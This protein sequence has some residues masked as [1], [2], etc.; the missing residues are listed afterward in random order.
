MPDPL[1]IV[2]IGNPNTGK[3]TVFGS[4]V[5][6]RQHVANYPGVTVEKHVGRAKLEGHH[7]DFVDLPGTYSLAPRSMDEMVTVDVLLG[8]AEGERCPDAVLCVVDANNLERNLYLLSQVLAL[9][10]PTVVALNMIDVAER[11]GQSIDA[12]RLAERL[13][14]AVVRT[15][16]N[17]RVGV[18][19]LKEALV[20]A[21]RVGPM[22]H[23]SA[24]PED[25]QREV[26][27]L[28][29]AINVKAER[30]VPR[31]LVE[32]LVLDKG[33]YV[34]RAGLPD[35]DG[36]AIERVRK[37]RRRLAR[38]GHAVPGIET[39]A[40]YAW[41]ERIVAGTVSCSS[42]STA[43]HSDAIDKVLTHWC[44][45]TVFFLAVVTAIFQA[46]FR[47]AGPLMDLVEWGVG[48]AGG[49]IES[50]MAQGALRS[51]LV[52]G[53][54]AGVGGILVFLPQIFILFLFIAVL[55]D[56][57]YMARAAYLTDRMMARVGLSGKSFIPLLSSFAC[58]VPGIMATRVIEDRRDRLITILVAPLMSCGARLP[59]Y[60]LLIAAFVPTT[61]YLGG[62]VGLQG[63]TMLAM[64][65]LGI[66]TAVVVAFVLKRTMFRG[67]SPPFLMELP[68][69][70]VPSFRVVLHRILE[71]GWAFL[72]N[73]G[74]LILA[75]SVVVW[76]IAYY[77]RI[78]PETAPGR[79]ETASTDAP[80]DASAGDSADDGASEDAASQLRQSY[81]G[82]M[83]RLIEPIVRPLG[84]DWRIGCAVIASFPAREVVVST[85]AVIYKLGEEDDEE[86]AA[87]LKEKLRQVTWDGTDRP[88][89]NLPVALSMMVFFSLCA[90][91]VATLA[92]IRRETNS[93]RW[94]AFTF[95]YMTVLA[96]LGA[97]VTYQTGM[98]FIS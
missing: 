45:G 25:F 96:Y 23:P 5:G 56:C 46:I 36:E 53:V 18:A 62:W 15:Q 39:T 76:A 32:R 54:V 30:P 91:C 44:F 58:A 82:R 28:A 98:L 7:V 74:T 41:A 9:G 27:E 78:E 81:L 42:E 21:V 12:A 86:A 73:A 64:Y 3:S 20:E 57:G 92:T 31:Y 71:R 19:S 17:K 79:G 33:G 2:L 59:V 83:G 22:V 34:E 29:D 84:W 52:D 85:L 75:T 35:F 67:A 10:L 6:V 48:L 49:G 97:L 43:T 88:V 95:G 93:W 89:Y 60:T 66:V 63:L 72:R 16:A 14:V 55:E 38:G 70:K 51:L 69:Y 4:L 80:G 50:V 65:L 1:T 77:P 68:S 90:Q 87:A 13:G 37:A 11:N 8:R 61:E 40:R 26:A 47:W 24:F 94:P